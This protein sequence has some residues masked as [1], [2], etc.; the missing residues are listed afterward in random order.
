MR[1]YQE[2]IN[3]TEGG[4]F[5]RFWQKE[6]PVDHNDP[7][8]LN[9][10]LDKIY[11]S[12]MDV[13]NLISDISDYAVN[14]GGDEYLKHFGGRLYQLSWKWV[15]E[16]EQVRKDLPHYK[17][18]GKGMSKW[19]HVDNYINGVTGR[20]GAP[21]GSEEGRRRMQQ[22]LW[23]AIDDVRREHPEGSTKHLRSGD[24]YNSFVYSA[25]IERLKAKEASGQAQYENFSFLEFL[26]DKPAMLKQFWKRVEE[27]W[28]DFLHALHNHMQSNMGKY[29]AHHSKFG[30]LMGE[31]PDN[32]LER[33][34][35]GVQKKFRDV[36]NALSQL[37]AHEMI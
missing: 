25:A 30:N 14:R 33:V 16:F 5:R 31:H 32:H 1:S 24:N 3:E 19:D 9:Q 7:K 36:K 13:H 15:N 4:I 34:V 2:Y 35:K 11:K 6:Q 22:D 20:G 28:I 23:R 29:D 27:S 37:G 18:H 26:N 8:Q 12:L 17:S 10:Y 21:Q